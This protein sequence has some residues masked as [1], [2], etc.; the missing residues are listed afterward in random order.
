MI[1]L[2]H[3]IA[4][5]TK[6]LVA[7]RHAP[8]THA[9]HNA[10]TDQKPCDEQIITAAQQRLHI[11]YDDEQHNIAGWCGA[12]ATRIGMFASQDIAASEEL[13]YDYRFEHS[14]PAP[15]SVFMYRYDCL[16]MALNMC[17]DIVTFT[18]G[19]HLCICANMV[20]A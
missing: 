13:S 17:A 3:G 11:A 18:S 12:G 4:A 7:A 2:S 20:A 8:V 15:T 10:C 14:G 16:P 6:L 5:I 9:E 1:V 19:L